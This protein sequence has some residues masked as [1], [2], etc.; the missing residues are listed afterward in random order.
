MAKL[1]ELN[2]AARR[3]ILVYG[4]TGVGKTLY[5]VGWPGRKYVADFDAKL[6][7]AANFYAGNA[8]VLDQIEYDVYTV[9]KPFERFD[10]WLRDAS[11]L[12]SKGDFP[13]QTV[14]IDSLTTL[15]A[16]MLDDFMTK[17]AAVQRTRTSA[18]PIPSMLDYRAVTIQVRGLFNRLFALPC[19][20]VVLAHI[21]T[22][23]DELTGQIVNG[24]E[25]PNSIVTYLQI[26][27]EE[28][29]R[30]YIDGEG[31]KRRYMAQTQSTGQYPAR[32]QIRGMPA[33][34]ELSYE[35]MKRHGA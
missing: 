11:V 28:V 34:V 22:E 9:D 23:K 25:G 6:S 32:S 3:R 24:P 21:R 15:I 12:A 5:A 26:I 19:H 35:A 18:G 8:Q 20:I 29:Y 1:S 33:A 10:G 31:D 2:A 30:A 16:A 27:F 14:I 17:N 7:S 4:R 13:F